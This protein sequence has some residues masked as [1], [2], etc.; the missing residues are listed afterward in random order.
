M[1]RFILL[2]FLFGLWVP[3]AVFAQKNSITTTEVSQDRKGYANL[4]ITG[5]GSIPVRHFM[6]QLF[7]HLKDFFGAL[8]IKSQYQY[9]GKE[10]LD[11]NLHVVQQKH[12]PEAILIFY[13]LPDA[14]DTLSVKKNREIVY[15]LLVSPYRRQRRGK[16]RKVRVDKTIQVAMWEVAG[17][18]IIWQGE[19]NIYGNPALERFYQETSKLITDELLRHGLA[20]G[21]AGSGMPPQNG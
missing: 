6:D 16:V 11:D 18:R 8:Q 2:C 21:N 13:E 12:Q 20:T 1:N 10:N 4:L 14:P 3:E 19:L 9:I 15:Q 7:P 5:Y 17:N